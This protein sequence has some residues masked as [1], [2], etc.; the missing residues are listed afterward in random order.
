MRMVVEETV[1]AVVIAIAAPKA[2]LVSD[3]IVGILHLSVELHE[4][5]GLLVIQYYFHEWQEPLFPSSV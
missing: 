1:A 2:D 4:L 3:A 5:A